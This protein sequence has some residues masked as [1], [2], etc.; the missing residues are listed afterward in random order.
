MV[1]MTIDHQVAKTDATLKMKYNDKHATVVMTRSGSLV[2]MENCK[3]EFKLDSNI[4]VLQTALLSAE[5]IVTPTKH[6]YEVKTHLNT[7]IFE[8]ATDLI[9]KTPNEH[10]I[11]ARFT[12]PWKI[13]P[14]ARKIRGYA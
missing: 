3:V 8:V 9:Q 2:I 14:C 12:G 4:E 10:E 13:Q 11:V 5:R 7:Q 6:T 1:V